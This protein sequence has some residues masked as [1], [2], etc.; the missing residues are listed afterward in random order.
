MPSKVL[1]EVMIYFLKQKSVKKILSK[2]L[3][4]KKKTISELYDSM[5]VLSLLVYGLLILKF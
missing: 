3:K 4:Q 1:K 5:I 2:R